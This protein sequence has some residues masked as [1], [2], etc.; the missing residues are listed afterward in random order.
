[1]SV[2][3]GSAKVPSTYLQRLGRFGHDSAALPLRY[4]SAALPLRSF[5]ADSSSS[6]STSSSSSSSSSV[7][8]RIAGHDPVTIPEGYVA[9][10]G[11]LNSVQRCQALCSKQ[12]VTTRGRGARIMLEELKRENSFLDHTYHLEKS[13]RAVTSTAATSPRTSSMRNGGRISVS[14]GRSLVGPRRSTR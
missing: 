8:P 2:L 6:S 10:H 13:R 12:D 7:L 9:T 3:C 14:A 4:D 5:S 11:V 1:M